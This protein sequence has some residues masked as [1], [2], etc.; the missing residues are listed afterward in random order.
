MAVRRL[1][2]DDWGFPTS[3]F[4]CEERNEAG[5]RIPFSH[6][7]EAAVVTA[8]IELDERFSGAPTYLHGGISLAVLDEA[9][10]WATIAIAGRWAVTTE[11]GARFLHPVRV[12]RRY[13]VEARVDA[14]DGAVLRTSAVLRDGAGRP[15][16]EATATFSVLTELQALEATGLD[17]LGE[18]HDHVR[19]P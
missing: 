16:V 8:E 4:V 19:R 2:N 7:D 18:H 5:L 14:D 12:G 3:C 10:A 15:C 6:D 11:M 17:D 9:Q 13:A 1:T